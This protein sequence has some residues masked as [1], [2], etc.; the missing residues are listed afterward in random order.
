MFQDGQ[1]ATALVSRVRPELRR[2][3]QHLHR[4]GF[5]LVLTSS[6]EIRETLEVFLYHGL[7]INLQSLLEAGTPSQ[8]VYRQLSSSE[9]SVLIQRNEAAFQRPQASPIDETESQFGRTFFATEYPR[10]TAL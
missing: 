5:D 10:Y 1:S 9:T 4:A 2:R 7:Q 6:L 3:R 8:A